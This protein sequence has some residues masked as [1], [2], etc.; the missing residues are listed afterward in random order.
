MGD[1]NAVSGFGCGSVMRG[2]YRRALGRA[3]RAIPALV[4]F[5]AGM[6]PGI[7][8]AEAATAPMRLMILGDS[9]TAGYGLP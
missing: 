9:L 3:Q 2:S 4:F 5:I 1:R 7:V 8:P 6:L